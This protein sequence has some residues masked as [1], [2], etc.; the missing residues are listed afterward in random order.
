VTIVKQG[1]LEIDT[2]VR[3]LRALEKTATNTSKL[4]TRFSE[5]QSKITLVTSS[6]RTLGSV[7]NDALVQGRKYNIVMGNLPHSI[8]AATRSLKGLVTQYDLALSA[9]KASALG[10]GLNAQ[11]F[12]TMAKAAVVAGEKLGVDARKSLDDIVVGLGRMSPKILDNLGIIVKAESAYKAYADTMGTVPG[13][14][15]EAE[16]R[17]AFMTAAMKA[18]NKIAGDA[19]IKVD[20][21]GGAWATFTTDMKDAK[22]KATGLIAANKNLA[23]SFNV[24]AKSVV[25]A[26]KALIA[27]FFA[28]DKD[29]LKEMEERLTAKGK[30][31]ASAAAMLKMA[32]GGALYGPLGAVLGTGVAIRDWY[33]GKPSKVGL[34]RL[35]ARERFRVTQELA[36]GKWKYGAG[37]EHLDP[38]YAPPAGAGR[39]GRGR[40]RRR[41]PASLLDLVGGAGS[42]ELPGFAQLFPEEEKRANEAAAARESAQ[43]AKQAADLDVARANAKIKLDEAE[44]RQ[45]ATKEALIN[46]EVEAHNIF[47]KNFNLLSSVGVNALSSFAGSIW[48]AADAAASGGDS[49]EVA[50]AKILKAT[51]MGIAKESTVQAI[52]QLA[53]AFGSWPDVAGMGAHFKSAALWGAAGIAAGVA[54]MSIS[55]GGAGAS[56]RA[57][58]RRA[59]DHTR[60]TAMGGTR[61]GKA[62]PIIINLRYD[63]SDPKQRE[64]AER[65]LRAQLAA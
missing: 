42:D 48:E 20:D 21:L 16:K 14:L 4:S 17:T 51:L 44:R 56:S 3:G 29:R 36:V 62:A 22:Q 9:S 15:T 59:Y 47:A 43:L 55:S 6:L 1:R 7:V 32:L 38:S 64:M 31:K 25:G 30:R 2:R 11:S 40:G 28:T 26:T 39:K 49:F 23:A 5:L 35:R 12:A 37:M 58:P 57:A 13:K 63:R 45:I 65:R 50:M 52:K 60:P 54:G 18:L 19:K 61:D 41:R 27:Y 8:A 24:V 10:L 34:A 33:K 46:K 53:L